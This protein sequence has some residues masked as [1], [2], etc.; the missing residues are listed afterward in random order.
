MAKDLCADVRESKYR[1]GRLDHVCGIG[2]IAKLDFAR[3]PASDERIQLTC[4]IADNSRYERVP[5]ERLS[6]WTWE[7]HILPETG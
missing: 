1:L 2:K 6:L 7:T 4:F 5:N 3:M